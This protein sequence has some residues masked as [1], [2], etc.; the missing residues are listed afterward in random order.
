MDE[1]LLIPQKRFH[2][3]V[4]EITAEIRA[5]SAPELRWERD[6]L[7]AL[8]MMSEHVLIMIMEMTYW[9]LLFLL[10]EV[11]SWLFMPKGLPLWIGICVVFEISGR[12][13]IPKV[14]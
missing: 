14:P 1:S 9:I 10:I 2:M 4:R 13:S 6:A 7:V 5:E 11:K 12:Q 3:L 8:Q